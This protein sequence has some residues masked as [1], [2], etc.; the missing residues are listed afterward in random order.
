MQI[1]ETHLVGELLLEVGFASF[2]GEV[3]FLEPFDTA[4]ALLAA[5][6]AA[7]DELVEASQVHLNA[8]VFFLVI[9][10]FELAALPLLDVPWQAL[11]R[12]YEFVHLH[13]HLF[14]GHR[15]R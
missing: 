3:V 8:F 15:I 5:E 7:E 4:A 6:Q 9:V 14:K 12:V 10:S 13:Q 11:A 2:L 1:V